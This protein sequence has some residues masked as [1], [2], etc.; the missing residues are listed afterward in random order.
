[1]ANEKLDIGSK[2]K[3]LRK[4]QHLTQK[5]LAEHLHVFGKSTISNYENGYSQPDYEI[6]VRIAD[7]FDVSVDYLLS[8]T[9]N[10]RMNQH[11]YGRGVNAL[12]ANTE[13]VALLQDFDQW[14]EAD[15]EVV[16]HMLNGLRALRTSTSDNHTE[17]TESTA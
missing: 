4:Q 13:M 14:S 11:D 10:R 1:M 15:V 12:L 8:R 2:I 7:F 16:V 3:A 5:K 9:E 6:L 17:D